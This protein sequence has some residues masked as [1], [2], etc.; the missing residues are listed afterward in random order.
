MKLRPLYMRTVQTFYMLPQN[1]IFRYKNVFSK[2]PTPMNFYTPNPSTPNTPLNPQYTHNYSDLTEFAT[3]GKIFLEA[4][5]ILYS[6]LKNRGYPPTFLRNC[7]RDFK[8]RHILKNRNLHISTKC[9]Q[10]H[11]NLPDKYHKNESYVFNQ[12]LK[13]NLQ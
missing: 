6:A 7:Y 11:C 9:K 12:T 1:G 2:K 10:E 3:T 13:Q 5:N 8:K 4:R